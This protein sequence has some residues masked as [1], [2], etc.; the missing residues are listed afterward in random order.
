MTADD[1][2]L[3]SAHEMARAIRTRG[4]SAVELMRAHL[5]RIEHINPSIN[6][7]VTFLPERAL[8]GARALDAALARGDAPGPLAGLPVAHKDLVLTRGVRTTFGSLVFRDFIPDT[9]ALIVER[10]RH[11]GA[12]MVGKTNTPEF[13]AGSQ[14]FN[15]VFGATRNPYDLG[16]TSGGSSGGAAAA[17]AARLLPIADGSDLG[18]SLRNPASFCNV[19]GFRPS[20]GR[21][22]NW[23]STAAWFD[24]PVQGPMARTVEDVALMLSA[25]AGPDSRDP[26]SL[27]EP[28]SIF[29]G[30][31]AREIKGTRIAW[32]ADLGGL[33]VEPEVT[34]T[35]NA[36]RQVLID[37]GC[38]IEDATPDLRG[39]DEVFRTLRA[40]HFDLMYRSLLGTHR[41]LLKDTV[42][43]NIEQGMQLTGANLAAAEIKRTAL[44]HRMRDFMGRYDFLVAP[45]AQVLP[46]DIDMP[47]PTRINDVE[48]ET[49]LDWMRSCYYITVTG[50][51]A[52]SVPC[53]FT[54]SGLPVGLQIIGAHRKDRA[55]LELGFAF[56]QATQYWKR[57][58][59]S[60]D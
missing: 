17:L 5:A 58:P 11:A 7:I 42:V 16:K 2:C 47:Y 25:I 1:L 10:L 57:G 46:F 60:I 50:S 18:G 8:E 52:L 59:G 37:L 30:P 34:A 21:V 23:P 27:L 31:L 6:A 53:G 48:L 56:E 20:A 35:M 40:W 28:G 39:A 45:V 44:F 43:W 32:S 29:A 26:I 22:P 9:D 3:L 12:I 54:S 49:Y 4:I 15:A 51:P 19:V 41:A 33:P 24:L 14:T 13:G 55:V 38:L 36:S